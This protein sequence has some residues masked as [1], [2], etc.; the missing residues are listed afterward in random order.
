MIRHLMLWFLICWYPGR[1]GVVWT[2]F[3][4]Q[5]W[6]VSVRFLKLVQSGISICHGYQDF[7]VNT[8]RV[9]LSRWKLDLCQEYH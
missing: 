9:F 6:C 3:T 4:L 7:P 5:C 2:L 8:T 1:S